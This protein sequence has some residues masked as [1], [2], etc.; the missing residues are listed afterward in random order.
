MIVIYAES[1]AVL[2]WLL[3]EPLGETARQALKKADFVISSDLTL[4]ECDRTLHRAK[5]LGQLSDEELQELRSELARLVATWAFLRLSEGIVA[6]S[7][8][9]FPEEPIRALDALHLA[10]AIEAQVSYQSLTVLTLDD[11]VRRNAQALGLQVLPA[12][13]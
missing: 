8:R 10:S 3:D 5:K 1:S 4:V 9:P 13:L 7:R 12:S 11:R 6:R 2:S